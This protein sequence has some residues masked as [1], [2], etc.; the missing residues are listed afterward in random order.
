VKY[1]PNPPWVTFDSAQIGLQFRKS[2]PKSGT[3]EGFRRHRI[4]RKLGMKFENLRQNQT[5]MKASG[6]KLYMRKR[7]YRTWNL[8]QKPTRVTSYSAQIRH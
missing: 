2:A 6:I 1:A 7:S 3:H 8:R 4:L 5:W